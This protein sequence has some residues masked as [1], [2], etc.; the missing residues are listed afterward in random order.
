MVIGRDTG[1]DICLPGPMVSRR[2]AVVSFVSGGPFIDATGSTNGLKIDSGRVDRL[3]LTLGWSFQ[4]GGTRFRV[5]RAPSAP[6]AAPPPW[7]EASDFDP[8]LRQRLDLEF[9]DDDLRAAT[10]QSG[11]ASIRESQVGLCELGLAVDKSRDHGV[12][13]FNAISVRS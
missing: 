3:P 9:G 6:A 2:H 5:V 11:P 12:A 8:A 10:P 7:R 4:I 13:D 1:S